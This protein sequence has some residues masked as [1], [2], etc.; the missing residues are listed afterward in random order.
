MCKHYQ[1]ITRTVVFTKMFRIHCHFFIALSIRLKIC[2]SDGFF[3]FTRQ[4][5]RASEGLWTRARYIHIGHYPIFPD[6]DKRG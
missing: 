5:I 1:N 6:G 4:N 3:I 2:R